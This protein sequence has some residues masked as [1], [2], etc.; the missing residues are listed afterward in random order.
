METPQT[1]KSTLRNGIEE[2]GILLSPRARHKRSLSTTNPFLLVQ[3]VHYDK[4]Y[5]KTVKVL[6]ESTFIVAREKDFIVDV[7]N[8]ED[9][10]INATI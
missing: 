10:T 5:I 7:R 2:E 4:E 1:R 3:T 8:V 6:N 9:M